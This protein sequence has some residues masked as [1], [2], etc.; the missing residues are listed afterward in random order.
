MPNITQNT[1]TKPLGLA[2]L[3]KKE[4]SFS[5]MYMRI[6][7]SEQCLLLADAIRTEFHTLANTSV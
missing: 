2:C 7:A 6:S 4:Y 1:C 3:V 5:L